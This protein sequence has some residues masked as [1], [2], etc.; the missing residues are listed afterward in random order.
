MPEKTM[1]KRV[2]RDSIGDVHTTREFET[3]EEASNQE[4]S[5]SNAWC[6]EAFEV[7]G[8]VVGR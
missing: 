1:W 2:W 4:I 3:E 8:V 5:E 7:R 6:G